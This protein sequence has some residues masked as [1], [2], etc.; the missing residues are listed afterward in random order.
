M[1]EV[2][3]LR[4]YDINSEKD[5]IVGCDGPINSTPDLKGFADEIL[6][7]FFMGSSIDGFDIQEIGAKHNLL[8]KVLA[9]KSCGE[10]CGCAEYDNFPCDCYRKAY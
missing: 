10:N 1:R 5:S 7:V 4:P 8:K 9:T 2:N 6:N 3:E